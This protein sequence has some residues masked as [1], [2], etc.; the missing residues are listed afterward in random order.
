[1]IFEEQ[2]VRFKS[3]GEADSDFTHYIAIAA[4]L[5]RISKWSD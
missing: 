3:F 1:M 4:V 2:E 5:K